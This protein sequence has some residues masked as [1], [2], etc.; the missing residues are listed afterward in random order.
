MRPQTLSHSYLRI[1]KSF[2]SSPHNFS[3]EESTSI[4][5][6]QQRSSQLSS[7]SPSLPPTGA[8][9]ISNENQALAGLWNRLVTLTKHLRRPTEGPS[10][11]SAATSYAVPTVELSAAL[12][13]H[14]MKIWTL[15]LATLHLATRLGVELHLR[16]LCFQA[17]GVVWN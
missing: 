2:E 3:I 10:P 5:L 1:K 17:A 6:Q 9:G 15:V 11:S 8:L 16:R 13:C 7:L 4:Q 12:L 14:A